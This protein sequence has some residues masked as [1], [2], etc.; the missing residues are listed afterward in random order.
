ME[1]QSLRTDPSPR[2][3]S[4]LP[5]FLD[6]LQDEPEKAER[7]AALLERF[8]ASCAWD[9]ERHVLTSRGRPLKSLA[10]LTASEADAVMLSANAC[11][12]GL[13]RSIVLVD[14]PEL[15]GLEPARALAGLGSLGEDNQLILASSSKALAESFRGAVV[16]LV[17]DAGSR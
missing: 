12:I 10:E 14:R 15:H 2:K 1:Q 8:S 6:E 3:F 7:F 11:L 13:S 5:L 16:E 17:P 9:R 4:W